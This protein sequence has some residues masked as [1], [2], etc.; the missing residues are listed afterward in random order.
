MKHEG[1][2]SGEGSREKELLQ[3]ETELIGFDGSQVV[4]ARPKNEDRS[5]EICENNI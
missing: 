3:G 1:A 4:P 5:H 2:R